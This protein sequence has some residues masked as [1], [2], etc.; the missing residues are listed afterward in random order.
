MLRVL[1]LNWNRIDY[2]ILKENIS[3]LL[4][5]STNSITS[6]I[7]SF[8]LMSLGIEPTTKKGGVGS[9]FT[10]MQIDSYK[11]WSQRTTLKKSLH[12]LM[13]DQK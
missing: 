4:G 3:E 10:Q 2:S 8:R 6:H 9:N 12:P 13:F 11:L 1:E 5:A 7:K